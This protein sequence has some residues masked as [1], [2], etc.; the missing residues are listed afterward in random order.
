MI[1]QGFFPPPFGFNLQMFPETV[2]SPFSPQSH[3]LNQLYQ[4][5]QAKYSVFQADHEKLQ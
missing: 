3:T 5:I 4:Q 1:P 2:V